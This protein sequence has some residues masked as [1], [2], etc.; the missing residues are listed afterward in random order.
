MAVPCTIVDYLRELENDPYKLFVKPT[1]LS[2]FSHDVY[3]LINLRSQL[4]MRFRF[5][6]FLQ[7]N[8]T[9]TEQVFSN[10]E[11]VAARCPKYDIYLTGS[12]QVW[13]PDML[14][15]KHGAVYYLSGVHGRRVAYAP[16]FGVSVIP[17]DLANAVAGFL[18]RFDF[19]SAREDTGCNI[20]KRLTGQSVAHVLDPTLLHMAARYE[21]V[22]IEPAQDTSYILL[23][24]VEMSRRIRDVA[25]ELRRHLK[26]PIVAVVPVY[27]PPQRCAFADLVISDA[28]PGEFLGWV[29][30]S[31]F[32]CTNAFHGVAFSLIFQKDFLTIPVNDTNSR[33]ISLLRQLN[34]LT[35]QMNHCDDVQNATRTVVDYLVVERQLA[36]LRRES[37]AYLQRSLA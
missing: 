37:L 27:F 19:L 11:Q 20:I 26:L 3:N 10:S 18:N 30:R 8:F 22:I 31:S 13:H 5:Q 4:R 1:N 6:Q 17:P 35:R 12:D 34:L 2:S 36:I 29:K 14:R 28:G 15:G 24:P 9:L 25:I 23:Y 16:S 32:V 21:D 33:T 7:K